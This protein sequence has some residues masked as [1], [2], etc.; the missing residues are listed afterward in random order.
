M[1]TAS[2]PAPTAPA[3]GEAVK[4][5]TS[6]PVVSES[7]NYAQSTIDAHPLLARPYTLGQS[8]FT[9]SLKAA[10][11][12][13]TR[14]QP[15]LNVVD[16]WAVKGLDFAESKVP[17]PFHASSSDI[18]SKARAPADQAV[19]LV[20]A[21][22]DAL[23]KAYQERFV[24][25]AKSIYSARVAPVYDSAQTQFEQLKAQNSYVRRSTEVVS[26]LQTKLATNL[27]SIQSASGKAS[28]DAQARAQNLSSALFAE[29]ERV[30][31]FAL[32]LPAE[33][34]KRY[35]PV[36]STFTGTYETLRK[37]AGNTSEPVQA[38]LQKVANYVRDESIPALRAA[39]VNPEGTPNGN[40][41]PAPAAK[42]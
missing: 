27:E 16:Q 11:P 17:Y 39:I 31:G 38:R 32:S 41:A 33:S 14:L 9:Q 30:R 20:Q 40:A 25:P 12:V 24:G 4:K 10:E 34:R 6:I 42:K 18:V 1:S 21:Y 36:L 5:I 2:A 22:A 19:A 13:T 7:L 23:N 8:L 26:S 28:S 15:Q 29:L 37:E 3:Y 35:E